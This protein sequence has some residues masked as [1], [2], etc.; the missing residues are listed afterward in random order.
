M[1]QRILRKVIAPDVTIQILCIQYSNI[2]VPCELK[3]GLIHLL[4]KFHSL[5]REDPHKHLKEF[6]IVYTTM[7]PSRV[8]EEY[9]KF[10]AFPFSLQEEATD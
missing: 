8:L 5:T 1:A 3:S 7:R 4:P 2:D 10:K 9:I 6:H